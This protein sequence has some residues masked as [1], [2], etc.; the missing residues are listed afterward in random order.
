MGNTEVNVYDL[1][2]N[3]ER[4]IDLAKAFEAPVRYDVIKRAVLTIQ[5]HRFQPQGRDPYAGKR[6][7][8]ESMGVGHGTARVA[9]VKSSQ[10][11]GFIVSAVGGKS[12]HPPRSE[13][14]IRR[15]LSKKEMNLAL[16]SAIAATASKEEVMRRGHLV[17]EVRE[18]P[19]VV[20]D[21]LQRLTRTSEVK[22]AF[23][24]LGVFPD[25]L[26]AK[27]GRRVR[28]GKGKMRGRRMKRTVGPLIVVAEDEGIGMAARNI[29]GVDIE[30]VR[31]LNVEVMAPGTHPGRL[32]V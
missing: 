10:H 24:K 21:D 2:G 25:V 9:R 22:E 20:V 1:E 19:L 14:E 6:T 23:I 27:K 31:D 5:S 12:A 13:K 11:G 16:K 3:V 8:A 7:T 30:T 32:T 17:E 26:R 15:K 4:K 28:A 29:P 18:L